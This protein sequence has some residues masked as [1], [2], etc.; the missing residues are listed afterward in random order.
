MKNK[1][2]I[3]IS[4]DFNDWILKRWANHIKNNYYKKY[5]I[6]LF[7]QIHLLK[8]L[9]YFS[10]LFKNV[11]FIHMLAPYEINQ[12]KKI[13]NKP[14]INSFNHWIYSRESI[15]KELLLNSDYI[16]TVSNQWKE[17]L[18]NELDYKNEENIFVVHCGVEKR[19]LNNRKILYK[20]SNRKISIGFFAKNTSNEEDRKGTRHFVKLLNY[21]RSKGLENKFRIII[22]GY[23]WTDLLC[24]FKDF[25]II[26]NE[27]TKDKYMPSLYKS[28][29]FYLI[30]SDVEG[31]PAAI[32]E[33]M[34]SKVMALSTNIGLVRDICKDNY[35]CAIIDNQ[36]SEDILDKIFYYYNN[37]N[38]YNRIVDNGY[39]LASSMTYNDTFK[40]IEPMYNKVLS[41]IDTLST[42]NID[43]K[44]IQKYLDSQA[45]S[46]KTFGKECFHFR[47]F[48]KKFIFALDK[49][50]LDKIIW[51]I[52]FK[53]LRDKFR[54]NYYIEN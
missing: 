11:D 25:E 45:P 9:D 35:N 49:K 3:A 13:T 24:N 32:L 37:K 6:I 27:F 17:N 48:S 38:E 43:I 34:A 5:N 16:M 20:K 2:I 12:I 18:I 46:V 26:Y 14:V 1:P 10:H 8:N 23:G 36:N 40:D 30:L 4:Y 53:K 21:I 52:P 44:K 39:K 41:N 19:F 42:V 31:G 29:D 7:S 33:S 51:W 54:N 22:S 15:I 28:L 50:N 47:L